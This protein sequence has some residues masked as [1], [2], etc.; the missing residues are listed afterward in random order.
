MDGI[1]RYVCPGHTT[2]P[3]PKTRLFCGDSDVIGSPFYVYGKLICAVICGVSLWLIVDFVD[4]IFEKRGSIPSAQSNE[5]RTRMYES[6]IDTLARIHTVDI[7]RIGLMNY[8]K[9]RKE[10]DDV[11]KTGYIARQIKVPS[12]DFSSYLQ[13]FFLPDVESKLQVY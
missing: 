7:D 11:T 1:R 13:L 3:V 6:L 9:R 2:V 8:G 10:G 12:L 4:G 5:Q